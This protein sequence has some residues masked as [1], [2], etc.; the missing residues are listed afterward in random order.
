VA[1]GR[2]QARRGDPQAAATLDEAAT[3]AFATGELQGVGPVAAARAE[4]AWLEGE[5]ERVA[6]EA[7]R[8][9]ELAMEVG[10]PWYAGELAFWLWRVAALAEIPALAAE[11]YR[12]LMTGEWRVAASAWATMG[13]PY[14]QAEALA[15]GDEEAT[16]QAL[17]LLD[18][19]GAA[20]A[21]QRLRR[22]LRQKGS[23]R[24]PRGPSRTTTA[25]PA[26]LTSRQLEV[27]RLLTEGL[28]NPEIAARLSLSPRTVDHHV[29]AVLAKLGVD[30][31]RQATTAAR[32]LGVAMVKD[33][34]PTGS[35]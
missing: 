30:S 21:A 29:S 19:L 7:S 18:R 4:H 3:W 33:G 15:H 20:K 35:S 27:L 14:E 23:L 11:P 22:E 13:C 32:R 25:N 24:I 2:L 26:G 1:L 9:F 17:R 31:R 5:P 10:H 12:L 16:A 6:S 28:S 34:R 8:G